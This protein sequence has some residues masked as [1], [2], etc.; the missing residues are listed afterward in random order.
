MSETIGFALL[1]FTSF[2]SL[3]NPLGIMPVFMSMTHE[4]NE[5]EKRQ[6]ARKAMIAAFITL[7]V[8][9]FGG[10][11]LFA[12]F[13]ISVNSFRIAGGIIFFQ[14]GADMLQ[15]RLGSVKRPKEAVEEYVT[16]ISITPLAIPMICG[17]GA[18]TNAIVLMEDAA[19]IDKQAI[20]VGAVLGLCLMTYFIL[21]SSTKISKLLG[22]AGNK[23]LMRLMGLILMVI[24]VEFFFSGFKPIMVDIFPALTQPA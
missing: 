12:F 20:L 1:C 23:I 15:A 19:T 5:L 7:M 3:L 2:F 21:A 16:D 17:P 14:M 10:Q 24:A 18:I 22:S 6:T 9:A 4:L 11:L 13:G 8:F